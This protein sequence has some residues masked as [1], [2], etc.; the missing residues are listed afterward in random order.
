MVEEVKSYLIPHWHSCSH[1]ITYKG[2]ILKVLKFI[3]SSGDYIIEIHSRLRATLTSV[4]YDRVDIHLYPFIDYGAVHIPFYGVGSTRLCRTPALHT[5]ISYESMPTRPQL[6]TSPF[7]HSDNDFVDCSCF[8]VP[9]IGKFMI[10]LIQDVA[11]YTCPYNLSPRLWKTDITS[12]M[13]SFCSSK[14]KGVSSL[15]FVPQIQWIIA[16]SLR[17]SCF[18]SCLFCS[19]RPNIGSPLAQDRTLSQDK[20]RQR[21]EVC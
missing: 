8:L 6:L 21:R 18:S 12:S 4:I 10:E 1:H 9:G 5:S 2:I 20:W 13:L 17:H 14:T 15:S 11:Q 19:L 16:W 3:F 7:T